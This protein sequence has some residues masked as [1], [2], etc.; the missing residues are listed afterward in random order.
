MIHRAVISTISAAVALVLAQAAAAH[1]DDSRHSRDRAERIA[2]TPIGTFDAGAAGSAEIVAFDAG[3]KRLFLVNA[4]TKSVDILD[5][6]KIVD[7]WTSADDVGC[8]KPCPDLF[9]TAA[10]EAD[11][12]PDEALVV[13]DTPFDIRAADAAGIRTVAVRSGL[14]ADEKL[15]GAIAIYDNVADLLERFESSPLSDRSARIR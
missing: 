11:V 8:S 4:Q 9:Q 7:G 3:S 14:F 6:R 5:A 1:G 13:G 12:A 10:R 2:L 15:D